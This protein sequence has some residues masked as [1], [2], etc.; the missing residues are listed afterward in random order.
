MYFYLHAKSTTQVSKPLAQFARRGG[1]AKNYSKSSLKGY[2]DILKYDALT[3]EICLAAWMM[4]D[5]IQNIPEE[6]KDG[7]APY[8]K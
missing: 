7:V 1:K 4:G 2:S 6:L 8:E 5:A 3:F